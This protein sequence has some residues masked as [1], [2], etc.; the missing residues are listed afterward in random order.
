MKEKVITFQRTVTKEEEGRYLKLPFSVP[1]QVEAMVVSYEYDRC[2]NIIDF[3][4]LDEKG[5]LS[6]WSGSDRSRITVSDPVSSAGFFPEPVN[7]GQ[8]TVLLGAYQVE[9]SGVT[10]TYQVAFHFKRLRLLKGDTHLHSTGSDG[11]MTP[12]E[13][14]LAAERAG[15]D[16]L[17]LTDHNNFAHNYQLRSR[18]RV[19]MIPGIEWTHYMGHMGMLG[20]KRPFKSFLSNSLEETREIA[21][22]AG[23]E[24]AFRVL[25]H[26]FCPYCGWRWGMDQVDFDGVE[27]W[28]GGLPPESNR[29]CLEWW[30][31]ALKKGKRIPMTG[32]SDFHRYEPGRMPASPCT[33]VYA[34]SDSGEDILEGLKQGHSYL[35]LSPEGPMM[36]TEAG[37]RLTGDGVPVGREIGFKFRN[38]KKGDVL[39]LITEDGEE[40][41][42][43]ETESLSICRIPQKAG[44]LRAEV[45]RSPFAGFPMIPVL[46]S[47]PYY[48]ESVNNDKE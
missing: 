10:V 35:T 31:E 9:D 16:F 30:D 7:R 39:Y 20:R 36:E 3:G 40:E 15:L 32:G 21:R 29:A 46:I 14:A 43:C 45:R 19:T 47:N 5:E 28:N 42:R 11:S 12:D 13:L 8:W 6:G 23:K 48:I 26:P 22:A 18:D 24:G 38:L 34:L 25:N 1:D 2:G 37:G 27:V 33:C 41:I 17:F 4:L 44:Y